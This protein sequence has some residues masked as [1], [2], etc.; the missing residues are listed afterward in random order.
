MKLD[1]EISKGVRRE[2]IV[3]SSATKKLFDLIKEQASRIDLNVKAANRLIS[4]DIS[5]V[6]DGIPAIDGLGPLGG[7][8]RTPNEFI[9]KDS[10]IDR[11]LLL[12]LVLF[13]C[14]Q[15]NKDKAKGLN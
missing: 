10:L 15:I 2:P 7:E 8:Y 9:L 3:E 12:A 13:K 1:I 5:H 4:S 11:A 14:Y 6:P